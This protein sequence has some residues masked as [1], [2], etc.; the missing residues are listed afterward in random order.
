MNLIVR[1]GF[2]HTEPYTGVVESY[3]RHQDS[4]PKPPK[5]MAASKSGSSRA[6]GNGR[7]LQLLLDKPP[8]E[9]NTP[10]Y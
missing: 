1:D 4:I 8:P 10:F 7:A 2:G 5:I 3:F 6:T 9:L